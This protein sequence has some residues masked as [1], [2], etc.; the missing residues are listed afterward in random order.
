MPEQSI[1][2]S[3]LDFVYMCF[4]SSRRIRRGCKSEIQTD[5][6]ISTLYINSIIQH[7]TELCYWSFISLIKLM[8]ILI[9][10]ERKPSKLEKHQWQKLEVSLLHLKVSSCQCFPCMYRSL[11]QRVSDANRMFNKIVIWWNKCA[12]TYVSEETCFC[13]NSHWQKYEAGESGISFSS[14]LCVAAGIDTFCFDKV[15][16][17]F[18][19]AA[20]SMWR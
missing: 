11:T 6:L 18:I 9:S 17:D 4:I 14:R 8:W 12:A 10:L 3:S 16:S 13:V 1:C 7:L 5:V 15:T 20:F 2:F 19:Y